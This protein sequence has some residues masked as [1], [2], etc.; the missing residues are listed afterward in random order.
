MMSHCI[1]TEPFPAAPAQGAYAKGHNLLM[2]Y[3]ISMAWGSVKNVP[4]HDTV[5]LETPTQTQIEK[6]EFSK[7]QK[8]NDILVGLHDQILRGGNNVQLVIDQYIILELLLRDRDTSTRLHKLSGTTLYN[9]L[10]TSIT[11]TP[12]VNNLPDLG[13]YIRAVIWFCGNSPPSFQIPDCLVFLLVYD[14]LPNIKRTKMMRHSNTVPKI[15]PFSDSLISASINVL[16]GT[17]LGLYPHASKTPPFPVRC[18]IIAEIHHLQCQSVAEKRDWLTRHPH[19]VKICF[20]EYVLWFTQNFL[21]VEYA[22]LSSRASTA[23]Y[24]NTYRTLCDSFRIGVS[25]LRA[26][27][28]STLEKYAQHHT[29]RCSRICKFKMERHV[30]P[31]CCPP[32]KNHNVTA[33]IL[34]K[35]IESFP[36][37]RSHMYTIKAKGRSGYCRDFYNENRL[38]YPDL[39]RQSTCIMDQI[40]QMLNIVP[41]PSNIADAQ[42][43]AI[44]KKTQ[45][46]VMRTHS[47]RVIKVCIVCCLQHKKIE[48]QN[49][50]GIL[51]MDVV[52]CTICQNDWSVV[53][54]QVFGYVLYY[55]MDS[56]FLCTNCASLCKNMVRPPPSPIRNAKHPCPGVTE[57]VCLQ[58]DASGLTRKCTACTPCESA[59]S[60]HKK[61]KNKCY[62]CCSSNINT[63]TSLLNPSRARMEEVYMCHKHTPSTS[64]RKNLL[65][66][67]DLALL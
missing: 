55:A 34:Q 64:I 8:L 39:S 19:I 53:T 58:G 41:L 30:Q 47:A 59:T 51:H 5:P 52:Q 46:C 63:Y 11:D 28:V 50:R 32:V 43:S 18:D 13:V 60:K 33:S 35:S 57:K 12:H 24:Y 49:F 16:L 15:V 2:V 17:L 38:L 21:P 36:V 22:I 37:T 45:N 31:P 62:K 1:L 40:H 20:M 14:A 27:G 44:T 56:Y 7:D 9:D 65:L 23:I 66:V 61:R 26:G 3:P 4:R 25:E 6:I 54:V 10:R 42:W 29:E 67:S 48:T